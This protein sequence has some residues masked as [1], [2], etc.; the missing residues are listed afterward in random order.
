MRGYKNFESNPHPGDLRQRIAIG[1]TE[2]VINGE[3][4]PSAVD[5]IICNV[6]ANA[7]DAGNQFFRGADAETAEQVTNFTIRYRKGISAGMWVMFQGRKW[8]ITSVGEYQ[9]KKQYL[10]LKANLVE[11]VGQG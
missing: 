4:Y 7:T 5:H 11:G 8:N 9:Y 2:T 6:W 10:G 1:Y 3:G